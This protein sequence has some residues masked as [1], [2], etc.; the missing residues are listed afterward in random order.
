MTENE[1]WLTYQVQSQTKHRMA[2]NALD[3]LE[4]LL[5]ENQISNENFKKEIKKFVSKANS[6]FTQSSSIVSDLELYR[7][8]ETLIR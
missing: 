5:R 6:E 3:Y 7:I 1:I 4:L 2:R 8:S